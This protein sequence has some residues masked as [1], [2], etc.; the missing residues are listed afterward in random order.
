MA[1][2]PIFPWVP[3]QGVPEQED[4][5]ASP[6]RQR[7]QAVF[8]AFEESGAGSTL[9]LDILLH[10]LAEES[11]SVPGVTGSAIALRGAGDHFAC[12]AVAGSPPREGPQAPVPLKA[13]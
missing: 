8:S 10:E 13:A 5:N 2:N 12:R 4:R 1:Q 7:L 11:L 6:Q 9:A 3:T